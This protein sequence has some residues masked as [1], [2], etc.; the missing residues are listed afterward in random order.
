METQKPHELGAD[1]QDMAT[2]L[3]VYQHGAEMGG[4]VQRALV[5]IQGREK[6]PFSWQMTPTD[7]APGPGILR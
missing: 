1:N 5:Q 3:P 7:V 2:E 6:R 4:G